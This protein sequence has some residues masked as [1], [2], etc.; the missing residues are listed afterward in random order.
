MLKR[1]VKYTDLDGN[2]Q[3]DIFYFNI[4]NT[5]LLEL[6]AGEDKVSFSTRLQRI[7]ENKDPAIILREIKSL[8]LLAYGEKSLDGKSFIKSDELRRAFEQT[9]AFDAL[10]MELTNSAES[11]LA[12]LRGC[13][14][15]DMQG[16]FDKAVAEGIELDVASR[17]PE[18]YRVKDNGGTE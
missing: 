11:T 3:E 13:L 1:N 4:T 9:V 7:A 5:E 8:I 17:V 2:E 10:F 12:F 16:D 14:P 18:A 15:A 6:E